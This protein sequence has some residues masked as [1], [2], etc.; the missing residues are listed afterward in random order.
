MTATPWGAAE[1]A[2][3]GFVTAS[4]VAFVATAIQVFVAMPRGA[5]SA[6]ARNGG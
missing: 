1:R 4:F 2:T 3:A 5:D 6:S